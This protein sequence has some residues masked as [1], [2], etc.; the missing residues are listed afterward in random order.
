MLRSKPGDWKIERQRTV[1]FKPGGRKI[2]R[3]RTVR[4]L[5]ALMRKDG[6]KTVSVSTRKD[7]CTLIR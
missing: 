1:L 2:R 7:P 4:F 5:V 3:Q 6:T